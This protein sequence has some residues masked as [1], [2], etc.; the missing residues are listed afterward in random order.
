MKKKGKDEMKERI[1]QK[2]RLLRESRDVGRFRLMDGRIHCAPP[3][4]CHIQ[5]I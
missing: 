5:G 4:S 3:T 2:F 1:P